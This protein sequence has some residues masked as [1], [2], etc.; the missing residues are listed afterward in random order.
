MERCK[1]CNK[2]YKVQTY[3][4]H[5]LCNNCFNQYDNQKMEGRFAAMIGGYKQI[6]YH[7][8]SDE[9][10]SAKVCLHDCCFN[11]MENVQLCFNTKI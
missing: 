8:S 1:C 4:F 5:K 10:V 11:K 7:E 6:A 3:D 2:D 9:F